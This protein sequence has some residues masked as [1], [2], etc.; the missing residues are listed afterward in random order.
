MSADDYVG[1]TGKQL[2]DLVP[3][4]H[5]PDFVLVQ[6]PHDKSKLIKLF[7][8]TA[9]AE[10]FEKVGIKTSS[11]ESGAQRHD[12]KGA[13]ALAQAK[14]DAEIRGEIVAALRAR[15]KEE[16]AACGGLPFEDTVRSIA[17]M[18]M[19]DADY[20]AV[21]SMLLARGID[22]K[23]FDEADS[24]RKLVEEATLPD[25]FLLMWEGTLQ[26]TKHP[27]HDR[28]NDV[29]LREADRLKVDAI[30]I[31]TRVKL[32]AK[33]REK[34]AAA[35]KNGAAA[36]KSEQEK[37]A[38]VGKAARKADFMKPCK[39]DAALA[40]ITGE[41]PMPRTDVTS[42]VWAY[43]KEHGLQDKVNKR[44]INA[45][46]KLKAVFDGAAS[47]TMFDMTKAIAAHLVVA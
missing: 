18:M 27:A 7:E 39:P 47:L 29:L 45:D 3:K 31:T 33:A 9:L 36:P 24:T 43:I 32:A 12:K 13:A 35:A 10:A 38:K 17:L 40:A 37:P 6:N 5:M 42:R 41:G 25:L 2:K 20:D 22:A 30:A 16:I 21:D 34:A 15:M 4:E 46:D 23:A 28:K 19:A 44:M 8:P 14:L 26:H 1:N 11:A